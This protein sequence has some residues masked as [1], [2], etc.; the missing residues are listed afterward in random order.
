MLMRTILLV[1]AILLV[2]CHSGLERGLSGNVYYSS[3]RPEISLT[4]RD[5]APIGCMQKNIKLMDTGVLGGLLVQA[6]FTVYG[7]NPM[8]VIGHA[9]LPPGWYWNPAQIRSFAV[10]EGW[11]DLGGKTYHAETFLES[12]G[13]N[14]F[15][16]HEE[17]AQA[18][19]WLIRSY[20]AIYNNQHSKIILQY[21]E[22]SPIPLVNLTSLPYGYA[23]LLEDF[24]QRADKAFTLSAPA[25]GALKTAQIPFLHTQFIHENFFGK[26]SATASWRLQ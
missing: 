5:L 19:T 21:R 13:K 18:E 16:A 2:S 14:P 20:S 6:W 11:L 4:A 23:S 12:P 9:D 26:A 17:K 8:A 25:D 3:S 10:Q 24:K 15:V 1:M 7:T 22:K